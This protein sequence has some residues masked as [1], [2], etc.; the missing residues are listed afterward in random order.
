MTGTLATV[1]RGHVAGG[2]ARGASSWLAVVWRRGGEARSPAPCWQ[3]AVAVL[4]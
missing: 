4:A 3:L 2:G 1:W